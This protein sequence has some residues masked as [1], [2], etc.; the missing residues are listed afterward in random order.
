MK[1]QTIVGLGTLFTVACIVV[2]RWDSRIHTVTVGDS[3]IRYKVAGE[4]GPTVVFE[5]G[6]GMDLTSFDPIFD[7]I[8]AHTRAFAYDRPGYGGSTPT[9][10]ERTVEQAVEDLRRLLGLAGV[11]PP[12]V[13]VG[14]SL[15]G[16]YFLNF[17][18]RFPEET[19]GVVLIDAPHPNIYKRLKAVGVDARVSDERYWRMG[20]PGR[21]EYDGA[22][23]S[24]LA[25][26]LGDIPLVVMTSGDVAHSPFGPMV[27]KTRADLAALSTNGR[28]V[29]AEDSS[30]MMIEDA[31]GLV[32]KCVL[33]V[34]DEA[35]VGM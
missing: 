12:Y 8:A 4:G 22:L 15:G 30:H 25:G 35:R 33:E 26:D 1:T 6:L 28:Q 14:H 3:D 11:E 32:I 9:S 34:L 21:R 10:R 16:V 23:E 29:Y 31:P 19:A 7:E 18:H 5:A 27:K 20:E 24:E 2:A 17:A 13:L